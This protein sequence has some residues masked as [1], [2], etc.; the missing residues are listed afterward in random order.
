M[1]TWQ[2][3]RFRHSDPFAYWL[4][5]Q[6]LNQNLWPK[7]RKL[8]QILLEMIL[9]YLWY[10][11]IKLDYVLGCVFI[12][13]LFAAC[14]NIVSPDPFFA[15]CR[16]DLCATYPDEDHLCSNIDAYASECT[17]RDRLA[18]QAWRSDQFCR[19]YNSQIKWVMVGLGW[20]SEGRGLPHGQITITY[21]M[22]RYQ[23]LCQRVQEAVRSSIGTK[24]VCE[25][26]VRCNTV[27]TASGPARWSS[28]RPDCI[29]ANWMM[30]HFG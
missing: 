21:S 16:Y 26:F 23:C 6:S 1:V 5:P 7:S 2:Y 14:H 15:N 3:K 25:I 19:K 24:A 8:F 29:I 30:H 9:S 11:M 17:R 12:S 22:Y 18:I 4:T 13:G 28:S 27:Y 20:V 10:P